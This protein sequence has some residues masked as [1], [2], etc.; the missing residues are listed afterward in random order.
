MEPVAPTRTE[1]GERRPMA[2]TDEVAAYLN[3]PPQ[4]L[5]LW[6]HKGKG[7]KFIKAGKHVRYRWPDV[8]RWE[9]DELRQ[10]TA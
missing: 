5:K 3:L 6:R 10:A 9:A 7:P 8:E 1:A 4:T 2:T